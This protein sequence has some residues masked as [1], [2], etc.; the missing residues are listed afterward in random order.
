MTHST[1]GSDDEHFSDASEGKELSR[2][3]T[4]S[5]P[6]PRTRVERVDDAPAH[7]E[8]PGTPA[9]DQRTKDAVPDEMEV[10]P[11]GSLSKRASQNFDRP[12]T[13]GG[14][15]A[16]RTVVEKVDPSATSYGD[17]P[18]S[19]AFQH[20]KTDSVPDLVLKAPGDSRRREAD[21]MSPTSS[22]SNMQ[23]PETIITRVDSRPAHGEVEGTEAYEKRRQD[24]EPDVLEQKDD[25]RGKLL[26]GRA[27]GESLTCFR[28]TN[29]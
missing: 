5:S 14:S 17:D 7:G 3:V 29:T 15:F 27:S 28:F 22:A 16:P 18:G 24:A 21:E 11:E 19:R 13:P 1:P 12:T 4:P 6:I 20:R 2:P 10:V 8:V 25:V 9:Y 23:I 26:Q